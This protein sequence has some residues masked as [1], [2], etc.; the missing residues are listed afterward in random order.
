MLEQLL[1]K[2]HIEPNQCL[3]FGCDLLEVNDSK[4]DS[5]ISPSTGQEIFKFRYASPAMHAEILQVAEKSKLTWAKVPAPERGRLIF[6]LGLLLRQH[7]QDLALAISYEIGKTLQESLGEVQEMIDMA[8]FTVGQSRMLNGLTMHSERVNHRMYEQWHPLGIVSVITAF[9]FPAAVWAWNA[10]LSVIAGNVVVW[11]PSPKAVITS[12]IIH[13]L[14]E[15]AMSK[16]QI[17]GVFFLSLIENSQVNSLIAD[18]RKISLVSFTGSTEVGRKIAT[19]VAARLGKSLLELSGNNASIVCS[20][21]N[22]SLV[23]PAIVFA[24]VGTTGQRCTSLRRLYVAK[25]IFAEVMEKL[26]AAYAQ[27]RVKDPWLPDSLIGPLIDLKAQKYFTQ[28]L[29]TARA[30]GGEVV[31]GGKVL[32]RPGYFVEPALVK[33]ERDWPILQQEAFVPILYV[34]PFDDLTDAIAEQNKSMHGL[35]SSIFSNDLQE[36]EFFLSARGSDC[37]IAN[38]NMGPSGAEIGGAFGGEKDTG[39]GREAGSDAWKSYMRRQTVTI[40]YGEE[41]PLAQ[42]INFDTKN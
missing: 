10:M 39:G 32:N 40:N 31:A 14:C 21:A 30:L 7:K 4:S 11:K 20:S 9:N 22:L 23:I 28:T 24:A 41:L 3:A 26:S 35:S 6:E 34:M 2:W 33:A 27:L 18:N 13:K 5:V 1:N 36:V 8:D 12:I 25:E 37:G 19:S 38:V 29:V 17:N 15:Q 16:L 42:G